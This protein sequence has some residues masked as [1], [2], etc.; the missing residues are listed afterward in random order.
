MSSPSLCPRC[1]APVPVTAPGGEC[2]AC[3]L[4]LS[5]EPSAVPDPADVQPFFPEL[6]FLDVIGRGGMGV[7]YKARQPALDR[8]VAV[9]VLDADK[10]VRPELAD[11]FVREARALARLQ[12]P[13]VVTVYD[14][15]VA[16]GLVSIVM[17]YLPGGSLRDRLRAGR[18]PPADALRL[19]PQLCAALQYAHDHG[20]V[21]RDIKPDNVLLDEAGNAKVADF[22]LAKLTAEPVTAVGEHM[23]TARYMA[24]EQWANTATVDNRAD[25]Y[26]LG[27]LIYELLTGDLPAPQYTPPSAKAGTDKRLDRVVSKSLREQPAER[28]QQA[29]EVRADVERIARTPRRQWPY[30]VGLV[31]LAVLVVAFL[32][33]RGRQPPGDGTAAPF[34]SLPRHPGADVPGS[35]LTPTDILTGLDFDWSPPENLGPSVNTPHS[36]GQ[37][38]LSA[39]GNALLFRSDRPG[40]FGRHDLWESRRK[41]AA[42]PW[43]EPANLGPAINS[44]DQDEA[45]T[46]TADGRTLVFV[47]D[48]GGRG[49]TDLWM[50]RRPSADAPWGE[51]ERLPDPV[52]SA[53]HEFRPWLSA[54]GL[55]LTFSSLRPPR[56]AV[57]VVRRRSTDEPFGTPGQYGRLSH[58][59]SVSGPSFSADGRTLLVG[60]FNRTFPG[61]LLWLGRLDN[62]DEPFRN[63]VSFGPV[64]NSDAIDTD[65]AA[66]PDGRTVYFTS[67]RPGGLGETDLWLTRRVPKK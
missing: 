13:H 30:M 3:L 64:V 23:G 33:S 40:G 48:R 62:P 32:A 11:R 49:D 53:S 45:P 26:S 2:P 55:T 61:N 56:D 19:V 4:A 38:C 1:G 31:G 50:A 15:S 21:H 41:A 59:R 57:W 22:G 5:L 18:L 14:V 54:D 27:V 20:V 52:N 7:V 46:L 39:D 9:K 65:P 63:L 42:D 29:A 10:A 60:R 35:P 28:Y 43:G 44:P 12:H 51:P 34:Q 8:V 37:P 25:I 24:P 67:D 36:E 66:A 17:E 47:S 6:E 58:T 16:D